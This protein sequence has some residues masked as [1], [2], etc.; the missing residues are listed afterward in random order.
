MYE[1]LSL[2]VKCPICGKMLMDDEQL[3]DNEASIR[4]L[5]EMGDSGAPSI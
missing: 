5:I 4:L 2:R 3:V 1:F